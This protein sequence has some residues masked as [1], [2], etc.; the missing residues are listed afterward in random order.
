MLVRQ[1]AG[2]PSAHTAESLSGEYLGSTPFA[3]V[4]H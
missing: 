4:S 2:G 3:V 1:I